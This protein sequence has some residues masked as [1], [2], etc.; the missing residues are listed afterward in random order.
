MESAANHQVVTLSVG[1]LH[2]DR[3]RFQIQNSFVTTETPWVPCH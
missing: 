3:Y 1:Q 2:R